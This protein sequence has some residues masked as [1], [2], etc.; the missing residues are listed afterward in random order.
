MG[1]I[2]S[3]FRALVMLSGYISVNRAYAE[4]WSDGEIWDLIIFSYSL[5]EGCNLI[6]VLD[7][8]ADKT[9]EHGS[10]RVPGLQGLLNVQGVEYVVGI[11]YG[12]LG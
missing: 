1:F 8:F 3:L 6:P 4:G 11:A 5:H 2:L 12:K 7:S 10:T 9:V